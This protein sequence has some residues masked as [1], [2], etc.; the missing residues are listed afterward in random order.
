MAFDRAVCMYD[1]TCVSLMSAV[2]YGHYRHS[3]SLA[4]LVQNEQQM[5]S[6]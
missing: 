6:V 5:I 3:I 2:L 1:L 4:Y